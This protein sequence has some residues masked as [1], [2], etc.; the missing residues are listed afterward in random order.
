M[1]ELSSCLHSMKTER[2]FCDGC[3]WNPISERSCY[4]PIPLPSYTRNRS[5]P[6]EW[7][8]HRFCKVIWMNTSNCI[9]PAIP[10][11]LPTL[12]MLLLPLAIL[13]RSVIP[14][15]QN[16]DTAFWGFFC[17]PTSLSFKWNQFMETWNGIMSKENDGLFPAL[18]T[19][20][21]WEYEYSY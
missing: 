16:S 8:E 2:A 12:F 5:L 11:Y 18:S 15:L 7:V 9:S 17:S 13:R 19:L 20:R 4:R 3:V 1:S 6:L 10:R 14:E 21:G